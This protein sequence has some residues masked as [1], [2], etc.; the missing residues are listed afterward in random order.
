MEQVHLIGKKN[1]HISSWSWNLTTIDI[2]IGVEV[3]VD[4]TMSLN[5]S[6]EI[7][8]FSRFR[9]NTCGHQYFFYKRHFINYK[10]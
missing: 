1:A 2:R 9:K 5:P 3:E 6:L 4:G 7:K 10:F 8:V